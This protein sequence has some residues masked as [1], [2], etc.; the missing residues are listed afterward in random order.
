M[1]PFHGRSVAYLTDRQE[2]FPASRTIR[3]GVVSHVCD[4]LGKRWH[5]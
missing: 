2:I 3:A 4:G 1:D 5:A